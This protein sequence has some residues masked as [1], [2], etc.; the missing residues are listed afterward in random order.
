MNRLEN[1]PLISSTKGVPRS[2][3]S[4]TGIFSDVLII[5][6]LCLWFECFFSVSMTGFSDPAAA[7]RDDNA[8]KNNRFF[9][10]VSAIH[11]EPGYHSWSFKTNTFYPPDVSS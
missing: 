2:A 5:K 10:F 9:K 1:N 8:F 3:E 4:Y 11:F 7:H 6:S